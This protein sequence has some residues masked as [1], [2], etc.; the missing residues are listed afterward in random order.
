[1]PA[2]MTETYHLYGAGGYRGDRDMFRC[3]FS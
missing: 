3:L 1:M 2:R